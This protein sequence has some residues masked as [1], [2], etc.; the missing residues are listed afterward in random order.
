LIDVFLYALLLCVGVYVIYVLK[1][2][3][4]RESWG[5]AFKRPVSVASSMVLICFLAV[6]L[7]DSVH[8]KPQGDTSA[9]GVK[10]S[11]A[12]KTPTQAQK[13]AEPKSLLDL[14]LK[15]LELARE[16]SYSAPLAMV[17]FKK[18]TF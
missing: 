18:E 6:A 11:E 17:G 16:R 5:S 7:L 8:V 1:T 3:P 12:P 4:L 14:M 10:S 13:S 15:P 2:P 9:A